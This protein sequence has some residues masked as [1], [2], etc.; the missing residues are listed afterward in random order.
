MFRILCRLILISISASSDIIQVQLLINVPHNAIQ[1][2]C[3]CYFVYFL[4]FLLCKPVILYKPFIPT[5]F[6]SINLSKMFVK[7][8]YYGCTLRNYTLVSCATDRLWKLHLAIF[9]HHNA[10]KTVCKL[11]N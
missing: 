1:A 2:K 8:V 9:A 3:C 4:L 6:V 7:T 5:S 11:S 10:I